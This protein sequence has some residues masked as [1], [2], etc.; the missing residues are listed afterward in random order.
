MPR[1]LFLYRGGRAELLERVRQRDSPDDF[2]YGLNHF[3]EQG[4]DVDLAEAAPGDGE[5]ARL[6][7]RPFGNAAGW[8][9]GSSFA[10]SNAWIHR[11]KL[12]AAD[13]IVSTTDGNTL[14][15]LALRRMGLLDRPVIAVTQ[16]LYEFETRLRRAGA[17]DRARFLLAR[18]LRF[19]ETIV[20]LGEGDERALRKCFEGYPLPPIVDAQFGVD[21]NFW[22]PGASSRSETLLSVGS[23]SLRDYE[24]LLGATSGMGLRI[25]TRLTIDRSLVGPE[26]VIDGNVDDVELRRLYQ[27]APC[28]IVPVKQQD[29]DSGHSVT[30]QAMACGRPV[31]LSDTRGLWDRSRFVHGETCYLVEPGNPAA[32]REHILHVRSHGEEAERVG[33]NARKL[34]E[35][36]FT[37]RQ[38]GERLMTVASRSTHGQDA[39]PTNHQR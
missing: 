10:L 18:L 4:W 21:V 1:V 14:P 26:V 23:D 37:S 20:V 12:H 39:P 15:L 34:V 7:L 22:K 25:V 35:E 32:L 33:R 9:L 6:L 11:E 19:A 29:R 5:F 28:V 13:V 27:S 3:A 38:F 16:G 8:L 31:I 17:K 30:L 2:L 24:T 36:H